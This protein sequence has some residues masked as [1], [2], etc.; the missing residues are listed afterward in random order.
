MP[1]QALVL[2]TQINFWCCAMHYWMKN[3]F[4]D[5]LSR[6]MVTNNLKWKVNNLTAFTGSV[7]WLHITILYLENTNIFTENSK[8]DGLTNSAFRCVFCFVCFKKDDLHWKSI[9]P[10]LKNMVIERKTMLKL[11]VCGY[12]YKDV[13]KLKD[14]KR[15]VKEREMGLWI[16]VFFP[17][18]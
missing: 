12:A 8:S 5:D 9:M 13:Q 2:Q 11:T 1:K 4:P 15:K 17:R 14:L 6:L 18:I 7:Y 16:Y 10:K 3:S